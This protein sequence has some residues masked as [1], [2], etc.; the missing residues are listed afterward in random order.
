VPRLAPRPALVLDFGGPVLLT[1]FELTRVT[2]ERAGLPPGQLHWTGP[3]APADDPQWQQWQ[4]GQLSERGY[5][6]RRAAEFGAI[7][8]GTGDTRSLMKAMFAGS[9]E[10]LLR[11]GAVALMRDARADGI[12][13]GVLTNDMRAFHSQ[14]WIDRLELGQLVDALVDGSVE[15]I[16]KPDPRIYRMAA[17]RLGVR[18]EDVVFID[19]QPVNLAG[20]VEVGMTAVPA[21]VTRPAGCFARARELLGLPPAS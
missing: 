13:V 4:A 3:F 15:G 8:G 2:E 11:P 1:P 10:T 18:C 17:G 12:P 19:D 21:D 5:W 7:T 9:P 14:E 20:A 6:A 16:L